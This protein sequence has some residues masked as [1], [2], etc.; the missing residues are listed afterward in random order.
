[1]SKSKN[2]KGQ[3]LIEFALIIAML[4][5]TTMLS[6]NLMGVSI[7]ETY[8]KII[9]ALTG[10]N[11]CQTYYANSFDNYLDDWKRLKTPGFWKGNFKIKDGQLIGDPLGA[12]MLNQYSGSDYLI[13]ITDPQ[14][15]QTSTTWNGYGVIFRADYDKNDRLDGYMFE[16]EKVDKNDPGLMYF[17]KWENGYQI[18][19]PLSAVK[20]PP[21]FDWNKPGD[22]SVSVQGNTFTAYLNG[23]KVLETQ[24]NTYD[25]GKV[26]IAVNAGSRLFLNDFGINDTACKE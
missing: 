12:L 22:L 14:L 21:K 8:A 15:K 3:G 1:M 26:G 23:E 2:P 24:D 19:P 9:E 7:Q 6:L 13:N 18:K 16:V 11:I 4:A 10:D 25:A 20:V 17:S 5:I